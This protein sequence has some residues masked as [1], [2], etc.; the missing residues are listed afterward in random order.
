VPHVVVAFDCSL[1]APLCWTLDFVFGDANEPKVCA[2][3][4]FQLN[5]H[6]AAQLV[7]LV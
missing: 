4:D 5:S 1:H 7:H 2:V 3:L 6:S